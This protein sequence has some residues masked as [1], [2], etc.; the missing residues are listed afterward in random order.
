MRFRESVQRLFGALGRGRRDADL[1]EELRLHAELAAEQARRRGEP[2]RDVRVHAVGPT[3][4]MNALRDQRG[5]PWLDAIT[6]D[7]VFG[8]RQL[9][10]HRG[11]SLAAIVSLGLATGATTAAFRLVDAVLLRPLPIADPDRLYYVTT[12]FVD[13]ENRP[14][15]TDDFDYPTFREYSA[16]VGERADVMLIGSSA[17]QPLIVGASDEAEQV[18]RQYLSG[19]V[20]PAFGLQPA[21]GRLLSPSDDRTPGAHPVAVISYDYWTRRFARDPAAIGTMFR[22]GI[23]RFEIVGVTPEG[24]TGTEPGTMTDVFV[25]SMMNVPALTAPGWSWFRIWLRP[26]PG[27]APAEVGGVLQ[28]AFTTRQRARVKNFSPETPRDKIDAFLAEQVKL[29]PAGSGASSTQK[30]FR[31]PLLILAALVMLVLLIACANVANLL[32]AQALGRTREMAL[33]VSIGAGRARLIQLVLVESAL[34]ALLASAAGALFAWWSAPVVVSMLAT[35]DRAVRLALDADWRVLSFVAALTAAVAFLFG[36]PAA[37]RAASVPAAGI[38][39]TPKGET[40]HRRLTT[41]LVGVQMT[42]C[43][44]VLFIAALFVATLNRLSSQPLGFDA[45]RV[46]ILETS[47]PSP[48]PAQRWV[49]LAA[50]L[51][52]VS[53]VEAVGVAGWP[54][55]SDN[56]WRASVR[57]PGRPVPPRSPYFLSVSPGFLEAMGIGFIA[58]RDFRPEDGSPVVLEGVGR[59]G[60]G[61]VNESFARLHFD[62]QNPV[63]A[64]VNVRQDKIDAP[65]EIVG[66]VRDAVYRNIR[67]QMRPVVYVPF[68][69]RAYGAV[70]VRTQAEPAALAPALRAEVVR[71]DAVLVRLAAPHSA[72]VRRQMIR[73]RLLAALSAFFAGVALVLGAVGLYGVLNYSVLQRRHEIGLRMALGARAIHVVRRVTGRVMLVVVVGAAAGL[74]AGIAFGRVIQTLL[75]QITPADPVAVATPL[76]ILAA[77]ALIAALPPAIRAARVDP[78]QTLRTE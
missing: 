66:L 17:P 31:R 77:A 52:N 2:P 11:A 55:L 57:V 23:Q 53:G 36:L 29:V 75:F 70:V 58:G 19:N 34:L 39:R 13:S 6:H 67:E 15:Y 24:F 25:P 47:R 63:G 37:L 33:R 18:Y 7:V 64:I 60:K 59:A 50:R 71:G 74:A 54:L 35:P 68:E 42:F 46:L 65:M 8:L 45:D 44:F 10:K 78:A 40:T 22:V 56:G 76:A 73:E 43:V 5:L 21:A 27:V 30:M 4:T 49:E 16:A 69:T 38:V 20:F 9:R 12:T 26:K 14:D 51:R 72:L 32:T 28:A 48:V 1:E 41:A 62:G 61:I 3:Q